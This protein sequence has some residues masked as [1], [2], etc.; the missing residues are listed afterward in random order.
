M[1]ERK[2]TNASLKDILSFVKAKGIEL[3]DDAIE[4]LKQKLEDE[5]LAKSTL[6]RSKF[7]A[8][9]PL[10]KQIIELTMLKRVERV[11]KIAENNP[12]LKMMEKKRSDSMSSSEE[13]SRPMP[14]NLRKVFFDESKWQPYQ[15]FLGLPAKGRIVKVLE[16]SKSDR[17]YVGFIVKESGV[18]SMYTTRRKVH[19]D[20]IADVKYFRL[21]EGLF[22]HEIDEITKLEKEYKEYIL[23]HH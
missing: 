3:E 13:T 10:A 12:F 17:P 16:F 18:D 11:K 6:K 1:T 5:P 19:V 21:K 23:R 20:D 2:S 8:K 4:I 14:Q 22:Q 7:L 15:V 9:N